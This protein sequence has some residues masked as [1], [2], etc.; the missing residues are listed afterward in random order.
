VWVMNYVSPNG[1]WSL[2]LREFSEFCRRKRFKWF[3]GSFHHSVITLMPSGHQTKHNSSVFWK[4]NDNNFSVFVSKKSQW[5][6]KGWNNFFKSNPLVL[7]F[8]AVFLLCILK[9]ENVS[10]SQRISAFLKS[11]DKN[12]KTKINLF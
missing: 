4:M 2:S 3:V 6:K 9:Y 8:R 5:I 7:L 11:L 10:N 12:V 1:E